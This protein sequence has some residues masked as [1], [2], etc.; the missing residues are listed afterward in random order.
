[1]LVKEL[2]LGFFK[3]KKHGLTPKKLFYLGL[4]R[5]PFLE[6]TMDEIPLA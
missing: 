5:L 3:Y 1:V 6:T 4:F 2:N